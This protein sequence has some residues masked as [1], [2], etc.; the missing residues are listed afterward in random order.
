[1]PDNTG[2]LYIFKQD[3]PQD[4]FLPNS[5]FRNALGI[6]QGTAQPSAGEAQPA[7]NGKNPETEFPGW[8]AKELEPE[9]NIILNCKDLLLAKGL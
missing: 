6:L 9:E 8:E 1:M 2:I 7:F 4:K 5:Y 3:G